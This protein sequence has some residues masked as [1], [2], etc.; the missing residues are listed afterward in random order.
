MY[1]LEELKKMKTEQLSRSLKEMQMNLAKYRFESR[2][3][4]SKDHAKIKKMKKQVAQIL[5]ILNQ[6]K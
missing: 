4:Q 3:G 5:T 1:T 2:T 6:S